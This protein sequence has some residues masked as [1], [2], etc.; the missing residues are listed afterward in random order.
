MKIS[1]FCFVKNVHSH[2]KMPLHFTTKSLPKV[3]LFP[4][5]FL[6]LCL[7][8]F[9][10]MATSSGI[11]LVFC[12]FSPQPLKHYVIIHQL[13]KSHNKIIRTGILSVLF[14]TLSLAATMPRT[15]LLDKYSLNACFYFSKIPFF[16]T[17]KNLLFNV[18]C[19]I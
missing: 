4:T 6:L 3:F 15:Y 19:L 14:T 2:N 1:P 5:S 18:M 10:A 17:L 9:T 8:S 7:L 12:A 13:A 11:L 16:M